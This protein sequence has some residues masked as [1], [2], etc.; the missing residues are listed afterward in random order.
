[1]HFNLGGD[2]SRYE[3]TD[4]IHCI[5]TSTDRPGI[6]LQQRVPAIATLKI[7][8]LH[9]KSLV[10]LTA[11]LILLLFTLRD[12]AMYLDAEINKKPTTVRSMYHACLMAAFRFHAIIRDV[13]I[14]QRRNVALDVRFLA[15]VV[16]KECCQRMTS[17]VRNL[18][19]RKSIQICLTKAETSWLCYEAFL[20]KLRK[21][22][23]LYTSLLLLLKEFQNESVKKLSAANLANLQLWI[24]KGIPR[25]FRKMK[26]RP[27]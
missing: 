18:R 14:R 2:Y 13:M 6:L 17:H 16:I 21:H 5:T 12:K 3:G 7:E 1:M 9:L 24:G 8:V 25:S 23:P 27:M 10:V 15:H 19:I 20:R 22:Q 26:D 4:I 11:L